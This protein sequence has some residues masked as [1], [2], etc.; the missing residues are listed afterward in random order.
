MRR[1]WDAALNVYAIRMKLTL[2]VKSYRQIGALVELS[3]ECHQSIKV[4]FFF[5]FVLI[6][7]CNSVLLRKFIKYSKIASLR[8]WTSTSRFFLVE[9]QERICSVAYFWSGSNSSIQQPVCQCGTE[10]NFVHDF[11][12]CNCDTVLQTQVLTILYHNV[13]HIHRLFIWYN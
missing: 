13:T 4:W 11:L 5:I 8:R 12:P 9:R 10:H 6:G 3:V 1:T 7:N 2:N